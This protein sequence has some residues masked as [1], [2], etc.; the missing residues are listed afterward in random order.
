MKIANQKRRKREPPK[1]SSTRKEN[2]L[3]FQVLEKIQGKTCSNCV[4]SNQIKYVHQG[5]SFN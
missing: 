3:R 1:I 5:Q 4:Q 2:L